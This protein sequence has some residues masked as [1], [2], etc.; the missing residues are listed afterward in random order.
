MKIL[1]YS[2]VFAPDISSNSF[3]FTDLAKE[4]KKQGHEVAVI[5]T[6]PHYDEKNAL[7]KTSAFLI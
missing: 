3:L 7:E 5:T 6:T 1:L 2:L 4:F